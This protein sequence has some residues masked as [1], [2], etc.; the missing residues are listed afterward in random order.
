MQSRFR[1]RELS[2]ARLATGVGNRL[3]A[4]P[5]WL[6]W[7]LT[8][9]GSDTRERLESLRNAYSGER[10]FLLANGPSLKNVPVGALRTEMVFSM[11]RAYLMYEEWG[12]TPDFYVAVNDL[13]IA[14]FARD[15]EEIDAL[16]F[17]AWSWRRLFAAGPSMNFLPLKLRIRDSFSTNIVGGLCSGGTVTFVTLQIAYHLGFSEVIIVGLDH[18]FGSIGRPNRAEERTQTEDT[19]HMHPEY[20]PKGSMWQLPDLLRSEIAYGVARR[21]FEADGRTIID[22]TEGG[23]CTAFR[24]V[25]FADVV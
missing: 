14:Q 13:V 1:L 19:D 2:P 21:A 15:I 23:F 7:H 17:V 24:K 3:A 25:P 20:F 22:A 6:A 11:N 5:P 12:F 18:H 8:K 4:V 9:E 16:K 10:C